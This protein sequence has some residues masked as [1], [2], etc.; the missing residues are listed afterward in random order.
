MS[1]VILKDKKDLNRHQKTLSFKDVTFTYDNS[2]VPAIKEFTATIENGQRVAVVGPNGSGKTTLV[3]LIPR[4]I[5]PDSGN[6]SIDG[7]DGAVWVPLF[8][9]PLIS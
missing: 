1:K 5:E 7:V 3:S 4:L 2:S 6:V 8:S 9:R